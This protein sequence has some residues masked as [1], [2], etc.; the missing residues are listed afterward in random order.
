M[1]VVILEIDEIALAIL[2]IARETSGCL[3]G[4]QRLHEGLSQQIK[5]S[6]Q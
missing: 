5:I 1:H 3:I 4:S 6:F 2:S